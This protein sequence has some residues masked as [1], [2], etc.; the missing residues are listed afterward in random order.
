MSQKTI[1]EGTSHKDEV[2]V[3]VMKMRTLDGKLYPN[4]CKIGNAENVE[5]RVITLRSDKPY[6]RYR[7]DPYWSRYYLAGGLQFELDV[8]EELDRF[9]VDIG[10]KKTEI[11]NLS[12]EEA[13]EHASRIL[14]EGTMTR[15]YNV[16]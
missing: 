13:V 16:R 11:F 4:H 15:R 14:V 5:K 12:P 9:R 7:F 8:H 3:Y 10:E 1:A 2:Y 6:D